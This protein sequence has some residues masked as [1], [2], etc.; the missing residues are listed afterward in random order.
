MVLYAPVLA[1]KSDLVPMPGNLFS[2]E[3]GSAAENSPMKKGVKKSAKVGGEAAKKTV[4]KIAKKLV[5]W[6]KKV[7]WE[8]PIEYIK[9][10]GKKYLK[11][12]GEKG[13]QKAKLVRESDVPSKYRTKLSSKL[14]QWAQSKGD[15]T[16]PAG[17]GRTRSHGSESSSS[18]GSNRTWKCGT[19]ALPGSDRGPTRRPGPSSD[20]S[21]QPDRR[22]RRCPEGP[23]PGQPMDGSSEEDDAGIPPEVKK[24]LEQAP[25]EVVAELAAKDQRIRSYVLENPGLVDA[26]SRKEAAQRIE[27]MGGATADSLTD[28]NPGHGSGVEELLNDIGPKWSARLGYNEM[29]ESLPDALNEA[30]GSDGDSAGDGEGYTSA[31]SGGDLAG[32]AR[33]TVNTDS[34]STSFTSTGT[35]SGST[36]SSSGGASNGIGNAGG[37]G[38]G[39]SSGAGDGTGGAGK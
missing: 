6:L 3:K 13:K 8:K 12:A 10:K 4:G 37:A 5:S 20:T 23:K 26:S 2:P 14:S 35:G 1:D 21:S 30:S 34:G 7:L 29:G 36:G 18:T 11:V 25:P 22:Q 9:L 33:G 38:N 17:R 31:R 32:T 19:N 39:P 16:Q 15:Q 24:E 28:F 27:L